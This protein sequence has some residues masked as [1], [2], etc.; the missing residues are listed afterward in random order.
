MRS[1]KIFFNSAELSSR[2]VNS[3]TILLTEDKVNSQ[4]F[5]VAAISCNDFHDN[6]GDSNANKIPKKLRKI[7]LQAHFHSCLCGLCIGFT[8]RT[9]E[10][11]ASFEAVTQTI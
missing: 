8:E 4:E 3:K 1:A 7:V 6:L 11:D 5:V 10:S 2:L 9:L